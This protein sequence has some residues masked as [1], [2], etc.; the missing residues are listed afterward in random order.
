M[1]E[2]TQAEEATEATEDSAGDKV[3]KKYRQAYGKDGHNGDEIALKLKEF[4][5]GDG[6][7]IDIAKVQR[8]CKDN[9]IE[10][11]KYEHLNVGMQRMTVGNIL[12]ARWK[13]GEAIKVGKESVA[14]LPQEE[15]A[16]A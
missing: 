4:C 7:K 1:S 3:G 13:K 10:Y 2:D 16:A 6:G 8:L 14:G 12:R 5:L 9:K 11:G 15:K